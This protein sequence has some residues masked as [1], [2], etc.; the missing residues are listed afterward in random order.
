MGNEKM[1]NLPG[2]PGW[3]A[4]NMGR[5]KSAEEESGSIEKEAKIG[6]RNGVPLKTRLSRGLKNLAV[7]KMAKDD[8]EVIATSAAISHGIRK[9]QE[10][11]KQ[12]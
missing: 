12:K 6:E 4:S 9:R 11:K 8:P 1:N 7:L 5:K 10:K 3:I 2:T